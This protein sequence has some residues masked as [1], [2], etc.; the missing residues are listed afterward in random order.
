MKY[1]IPYRMYGDQN[2]DSEFVTGGTEMF[3]R[4]FITA[5]DQTVKVIGFT[6]DEWACRGYVP[7]VIAASVESPSDVI[8]SNYTIPKTTTEIA[9]LLT[10][11]PIVVMIH[12]IASSWTADTFLKVLQLEPFKNMRFGFVSEFQYHD[13]KKF[14]TRRNRQIIPRD[15]SFFFYPWYNQSEVTLEGSH[16]KYDLITIGRAQYHKNPLAVHKIAKRI[17]RTSCAIVS[18][19]EMDPRYEKEYAKFVKANPD[20]VIYENIPHSENVKHLLNS[21]VYLSTCSF[22]AWGITMAEAACAGL[23]TIAFRYAGKD[24]AATEFLHSA[25]TRIV[26]A[27]TNNIDILNALRYF[28]TINHNEIRSWANE[29]FTI[30]TF[31]D[32]LFTNI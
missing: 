31:K 23:G 3:I 11:N 28:N 7:K 12:N 21:N 18:T 25:F 14:A 24:P 2:F 30:R 1:I 22:E 32:K 19:Y 4:R 27:K 5:T 10:V 9:K 26:D 17:D 15:R 6:N 8:I 20:A 29:H 13:W 16:D